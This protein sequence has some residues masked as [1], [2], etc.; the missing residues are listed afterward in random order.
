MWYQASVAES[1]AKLG[2][3]T[4]QPLI[5]GAEAGKSHP[6][7]RSGTQTYRHLQGDQLGGS[8]EVL[9]LLHQSMGGRDCPLCTYGHDLGLRAK[10][11]RGVLTKYC[12]YPVQ[13]KPCALGRYRVLPSVQG[14]FSA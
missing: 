6:S 14:T 10:D 5:Q 8:T 1:T 9:F 13:W 2:G 12:R 4:Q 3:E 11:H 7:A